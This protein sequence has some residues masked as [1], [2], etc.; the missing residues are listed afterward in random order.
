MITNFVSKYQEVGASVLVF[1]WFPPPSSGVHH[2]LRGK[3]LKVQCISLQSI[4]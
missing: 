4:S 2:E 1:Q 3:R